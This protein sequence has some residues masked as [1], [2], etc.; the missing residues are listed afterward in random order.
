MA[1]KMTLT[2]DLE[3]IG[4]VE[5]SAETNLADNLEK[6]PAIAYQLAVA[7]MQEMVQAIEDGETSIEKT[8]TAT[9]EGN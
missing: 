2:L 5:L 7:M 4:E 9:P 8:I 3:T 6:I 1:D